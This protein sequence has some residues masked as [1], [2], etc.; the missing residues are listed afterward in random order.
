MLIGAGM[1]GRLADSPGLKQL[2]RGREGGFV[3]RGMTWGKAGFRREPE[4]ASG[5]MRDAVREQV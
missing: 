3:E 5:K 4:G 2:C 1:A